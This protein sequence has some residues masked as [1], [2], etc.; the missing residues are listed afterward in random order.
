LKIHNKLHFFD[1]DRI[2]SA[3]LLHPRE[4]KSGKNILF[5]SNC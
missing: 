4:V 2:C 3:V 5:S 1:V